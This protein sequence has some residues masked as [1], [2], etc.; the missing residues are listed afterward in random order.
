MY[1]LKESVP[2]KGE[3]KCWISGG[4]GVGYI[5]VWFIPSL[6]SARILAVSSQSEEDQ[7]QTL[8]SPSFLSFSY[9]EQNLVPF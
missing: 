4:A 2:G 7:A 9:V 3:E 6:P 8:F 1:F 5:S